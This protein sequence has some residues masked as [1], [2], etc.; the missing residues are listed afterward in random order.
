VEADLGR[1]TQSIAA[2]LGIGKSTV[3]QIMQEY[4]CYKSYAVQ[5]GQF[6]SEANK[7]R[8]AEKAR[9]LMARLNHSTVP[10]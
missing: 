1:S 10:N 3:Q 9:K 7:A 4:L 2:E 5:K 8:Q 6:I